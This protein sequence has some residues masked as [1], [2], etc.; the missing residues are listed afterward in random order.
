MPCKAVG[1]ESQARQGARCV[2]GRGPEVFRAAIRF[3]WRRCELVELG[4]PS[5][6]GWICW[7]STPLRTLPGRSAR[8]S[9][10]ILKINAAARSNLAPCFSFA[11]AT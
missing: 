9:L 8:S 4:D 1:D 11:C 5:W 10:R 2:R 3:S 7:C 6:A